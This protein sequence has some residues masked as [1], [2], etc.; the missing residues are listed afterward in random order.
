MATGQDKV[1]EIK[2]SELFKISV[3]QINTFFH[4]EFGGSYHSKAFV[5]I[6]AE[7]GEIGHPIHL[8][9]T[10]LGTAYL[11]WGLYLDTLYIR[12]GNRAHTKFG[13]ILFSSPTVLAKLAGLMGI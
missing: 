6:V 1:T 7:E 9:G 5:V 2:V 3:Y 12:M 13:G 11:N 4:E 10:R 8:E